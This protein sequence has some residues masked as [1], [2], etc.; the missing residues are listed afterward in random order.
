MAV[1]SIYHVFSVLLKSSRSILTIKVQCVCEEPHIIKAGHNMQ[2]NQHAVHHWEL[3]IQNGDYIGSQTIT[4]GV[5][6]GSIL[7]HVSDTSA[8]TRASPS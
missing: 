6:K 4:E 5:G 7:N 8:N 2:Y 1:L 3:A